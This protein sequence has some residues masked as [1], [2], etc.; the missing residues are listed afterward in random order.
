MTG[1]RGGLELAPEDGSPLDPTNQGTALLSRLDRL[2]IQT[3]NEGPVVGPLDR[4]EIQGP[5]ALV[6]R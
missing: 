6:T 2:T 3:A 4:G 1:V 5:I